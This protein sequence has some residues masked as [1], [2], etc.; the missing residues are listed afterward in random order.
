MSE[1]EYGMA[2]QDFRRARH[3]A[4]LQQLLARW[5]GKSL[6]LL[7]Y[8]EVR[9]RLK[10][11]TYV[12]RGLQQ[13]PLDAIVGSVGRYQDFTRAFLPRHDSDEARWAG[14]KA[15]QV[16]H[17]LPPI[18]VYQIGEAYFV[19]DGNHRVSVARQ[20]G[21]GTI[22]AYVTEVVTKVPLSPEDELDDIILKA[23]YAEFLE[24]TRLD[25][26]RPDI[27]LR[28]TAPGKYPLLLEHIEV[29]RYYMGN[30]EAREIP[31][32]EA[33]IHWVD[34]VYLPMVRLIA[35]AGLCHDFP[36]RTAA[37]LYVWSAEHKAE[38]EECL[39]WEV[40]AA[41]AVADMVDQ[42][43]AYKPARLVS[44]A[45]SA[46]LPTTRD[47]AAEVGQWRRERLESI[48]P[49]RF[50]DTML[51][52]LSGRETGWQALDQA[53]LLA[54]KE[55]SHIYGLFAVNEQTQVESILSQALMAE[56]DRRCAQANVPAELI[57]EEGELETLI[58][59]RCR[60]ADIMVLSS[61]SGS[62]GVEGKEETM[63]RRII[64]RASGPLLIVPGTPTQPGSVLLAYDDRDASEEAL[65]VSTYIAC[66]WEVPVTVL[67]VNDDEAAG[68]AVAAKA[69]DYLARAGVA[70]ELL[71]E[72]GEV[73][74]TIRRTARTRNHDLIVMGSPSL[75]PMLELVLGGTVKE[76][77]RTAEVPLLLCR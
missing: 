16:S 73:A 33:V 48:G 72:K 23:E 34:E 11:Y 62:P 63:L 76:M 45:L 49:P 2:I 54:K 52:P 74:E 1:L 64:R 5:T 51:V 50:I 53:I 36:D 35:E 25:K 14:V 15:A 27:D 69:G 28:L 8:D 7:S 21:S 40:T 13:I 20:L 4:G 30:E 56:F 24:H 60:W 18:T 43:S 37:D 19:Q 22:E 58:S 77:L 38:V 57:V 44:R 3:R 29:H 26:L 55:E 10:A 32:E 42:F 67:Q 68:R 59:R 6:D 65:Y 31:Y 66:C 47:R 9:D 46:V 70:L 12:E 17:G 61:L 75:S 41:A 71:V 39:G